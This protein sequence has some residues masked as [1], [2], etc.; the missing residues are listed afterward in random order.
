MEHPPSKLAE[1]VLGGTVLFEHMAL[2]LHQIPCFMVE[3]GQPIHHVN[4][5]GIVCIIKGQVDIFTT[6]LDGNHVCLSTAKVG[7]FFGISNLFAHQ[8]LQTQLKAKTN[9]QL[10][11]ISKE[12]FVDLMHKYPD[13]GVRYATIC[14]EKIQFLLDRIAQLTIQSARQKVG[15]FLLQRSELPQPTTLLPR[16]KLASYLGM[17]RAS[18]FRE[19]AFFKQENIISLTGNQLTILN[20]SL[21]KQYCI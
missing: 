10:A 6:A 3:K 15:L 8:E 2:P 1:R 7:D 5:E 9:A 11:Y 16:E 14:N 17:S 20:P 13:L 18:V 19:L 12:L 4:G 21:L